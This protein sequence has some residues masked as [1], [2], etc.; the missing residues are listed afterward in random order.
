[1]IRGFGVGEAVFHARR[2]M[3]NR[4]N[5]PLGIL[6]MS[7]VDPYLRVTKAIDIAS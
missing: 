5:N 2:T 4:H 3:L 7:Y 6:Y 1:L